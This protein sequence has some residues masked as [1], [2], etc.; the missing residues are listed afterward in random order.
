MKR[1]PLTNQAIDCINPFEV[2]VIIHPHPS[3]TDKFVDDKRDCFIKYS[4]QNDNKN[5][6]TYC[7]CSMSS[8]MDHL[9][10]YKSTICPVC[11]SSIELIYDGISYSIL[12]ND[13]TSADAVNTSV[14]TTTSTKHNN[15]CYDMV[16]FKY[17]K[18]SFHLAIVK[19]DENSLSNTNIRSLFQRIL[20]LMKQKQNRVT[21]DKFFVETLAQERIGKVLGIDS[22]YNLKILHKGKVLYPLPK[23]KMNKSL[24][25]VSEHEALS[26]YLIQISNSDKLQNKRQP[27]L[28]VMGTRREDILIDDQSR[29]RYKHY[30]FLQNIKHV[31]MK[32]P[33]YSFIFMIGIGFAGIMLMRLKPKSNNEFSESRFIPAIEDDNEIIEL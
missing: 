13:F 23:Q 20:I 8:L 21:Q 31:V 19:N 27:S 29:I 24:S 12:M 16:S 11:A 15:V 22:K 4:D 9:Y 30:S 3:N 32:R 33:Y 28:I 26:K 2:A 6:S 14:D 1:C 7:M 25:Y 17:N 10:S 5:V 18:Q